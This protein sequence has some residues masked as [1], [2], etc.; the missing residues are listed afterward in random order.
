MEDPHAGGGSINLG[1]GFTEGD[2]G[3]HVLNPSSTTWTLA[4]TANRDEKG[5]ITY[6]SNPGNWE[7]VFRS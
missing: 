1:A 6:G 4:G 5:F 3:I 2:Y 7:L